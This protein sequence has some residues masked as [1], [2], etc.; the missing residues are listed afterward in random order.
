MFTH[1]QS[2]PAVEIEFI[3]TYAVKYRHFE[4]RQDGRQGELAMTQE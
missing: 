2:R 4:V 1:P 3:T